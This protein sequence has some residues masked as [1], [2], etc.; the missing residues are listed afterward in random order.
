M[1]N[2]N[3]SKNLQKSCIFIL[4]SPN[5]PLIATI[6]LVLVLCTSPLLIFGLLTPVLANTSIYSTQLS[7]IKSISTAYNLFILYKF[8]IKFISK[9]YMQLSKIRLLI[10]IDIVFG[11]YIQFQGTKPIFWAWI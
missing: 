10:T 1:I 2:F 6:L 4:I 11:E 9:V 5:G 3:I 7:E 8:S